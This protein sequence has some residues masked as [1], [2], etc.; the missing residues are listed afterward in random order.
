VPAGVLRRFIHDLRIDTTIGMVASEVGTWSMIVV[1]ATVLHAHGTTNVATAADAARALEPLVHTFPHA[2]YLAK[3]IFAAGVIGLGLLA[4]P[5]LSGSA[6]YALC[7]ARG[8][9]EGLNLKLRE[10]W[11]FYGVITIAT[12][13]GL[14]LTFLGVNPIQAL[15]FTAVFN[16][17]AAVPLLFV[18]AQL[19]GNRAVMG[20]YRSGRLSTV[21]VWCTF[22][23]MGAAALA[24]LV[25]LARGA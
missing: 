19:A 11:A 25:T 4:I 5:V 9:P 1:G 17:V 22:A 21:L 7:E 24:M 2:G 16:G 14:G 15:V 20:A 6:S 12:L 10:G 18:I 8:W 13:I 3:L 23:G